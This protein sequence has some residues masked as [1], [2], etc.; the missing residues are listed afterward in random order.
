MADGAI[1]DESKGETVVIW[2]ISTVCSSEGIQVNREDLRQDSRCTPMIERAATEQFVD[3]YG[4]SHL[5]ST[6]IAKNPP[7]PLVRKRTMPTEWPPLVDGI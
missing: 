5:F 6:T 7:W 1:N 3:R 4:Q 2:A